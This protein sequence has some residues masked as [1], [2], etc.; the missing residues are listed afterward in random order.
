MTSHPN[1]LFLFASC[2]R[3]EHHLRCGIFHRLSE[4][5]RAAAHDFT[6]THQLGVELAAVECEINVKVHSVKRSLRCIHTLEILLEIL[7]G[8]IRRESHNFL[9][10]WR[11]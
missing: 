4:L 3:L 5:R 1:G 6:L 11:Q 10:T 7:A 9:Y 8:K 2:R